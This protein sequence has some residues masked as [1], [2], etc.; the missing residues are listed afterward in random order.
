[1]ERIK[2]TPEDLV[3][4]TEVVPLS[5]LRPHPANA[6]CGDVEKIGRSL[7]A[8]GQ[9]RAII[10]S[11]D[12]YILAGNHTYAAAMEEDQGGKFAVHRLPLDHDHPQ[13]REILAAENAAN[14]GARYD[15]GLLEQ[16]LTGIREDAGELAGTLYTDDFLEE[17]MAANAGDGVPIGAGSGDSQAIAQAWNVIVECSCEAEQA[18]LLDRL[19]AEG[20]TVKAVVL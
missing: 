20:L 17:L 7:A 1:M 11:R 3:R 6:R 13:A 19:Q 18:E 16:L 2:I 12:D 14:D 10:I 8:H 15:N 5:S 9:F 4:W